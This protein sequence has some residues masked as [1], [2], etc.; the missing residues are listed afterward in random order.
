[1]F[2]SRILSSG[3]EVAILRRQVK[4]PVYRMRDRALLS[5]ASRMLPRERWSAFLVRP[6]RL[7]RWHR[8]L[9]ARTW[10]RPHR[11]PGRPSLD[12]EVRR[13]ILRLAKENP[14]WGYMRIKGEL[15][16]LGVR[17]SA[18]TIAML[19]RSHGIG[20]APRRGP[21]GSQFLKAQA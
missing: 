5:A 2:T 20:P 13:L 17:V 15:Q 4:R 18:T 7:L 11:R 21:T 16:G 1:M 3:H 14:R 19:L 6:E 9:V 10:T 12:P 8:R